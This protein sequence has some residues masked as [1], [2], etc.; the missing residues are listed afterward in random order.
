MINVA[1]LGIGKIISEAIKAI[2]ASKKFHI[3]NIWA[4]QHS[5]DKAAA[6]AEK[7]NV[8]KFTTALDDISDV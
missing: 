3:A 8:D 6:L 5:R 7:F 4:R 1:I 2:Q